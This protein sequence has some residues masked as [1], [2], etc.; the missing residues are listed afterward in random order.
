VIRIELGELAPAREVQLTSEQGARLAR[1][2]VAT[3]LPS[4]YVPGT[5]LIGPAGKIG[6]ARIGDIEIHIAPKLPVARLLFLTGYAEHGTAWLEEDV[7]LEDAPDIVPALA[8]ALWRQ[9]ARAIHQGLLPGYMVVEESSAVLRGR[10][11]ETEQLHRHH[12]LPFPLEI[13]HD[14][15][16][17]DIPENQILRT[18][19]EQM[20]AVPRVDLD[21]Q[22]MLRRLLREF[23]DVTPLAR[24]EP[25]PRWEATRL[26]ARY[27]SALRLAEVVL[28]ATS[29]EHGPGGVTFTGF[30]FDMPTLFEEF[31]TVALREALEGA[32]GGGVVGQDDSYFLDVA[33]GSA[34]GPISSGTCAAGRLPSRTPSTR[35]SISPAIRTQTFTKCSPTAPRSSFLAAISSTRRVPTKPSRTRSVRQGS[36]SSATRWTSKQRQ[37][38]CLLR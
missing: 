18:A 6:A 38:H 34:Y 3:A 15:F 25:I 31:A 5:W 23:T 8:H 28:R 2:G 19:C 9:V 1:S 33:A 16:T 30:L 10:L 20:L 35:P 24:G 21:S 13:R 36:K 29:V 11:L 27:H 12:G 37:H 4:P 7:S 14:E 26:N 22:R 17:T 32:Y